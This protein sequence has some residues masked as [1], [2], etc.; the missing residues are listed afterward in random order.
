MFANPIV[1]REAKLVTATSKYEQVEGEK[2]GGG[3]EAEW[4]ASLERGKDG[5][6]EERCRIN[7]RPYTETWCYSRYTGRPRT[8][9][10]IREKER[11]QAEDRRSAGDGN[12]GKRTKN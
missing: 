2:R 10:V 3:E 7:T 1:Y 12:A 6:M 9:A 5:S 4:F 8:I 11:I